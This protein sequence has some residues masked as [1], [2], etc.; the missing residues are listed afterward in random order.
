[1]S[2]SSSRVRLGL[3]AGAAALALAGA[4]T[5][6]EAVPTQP[7]GSSA[8]EDPRDVKLRALEQAVASLQ[9]QILDLKGAQSAGFKDVRA[10]AASQPQISFANGRPQLASADGAFKLAVRTVVQFDAANYS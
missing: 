10:A 8:P 7:A 6:Q 1:M 9:A 3:M 4:A 5:A 2:F